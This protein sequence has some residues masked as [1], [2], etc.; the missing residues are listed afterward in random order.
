[1]WITVEKISRSITTK[2]TCAVRV[3]RFT[4]QRSTYW[5]NRRL[6][7]WSSTWCI[8][9]IFVIFV[10]YFDFKIVCV[11]SPG[12]HFRRNVLQSSRQNFK[13]DV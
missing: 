12:S 11:N 3:A 10:L 13:V 6:F 4:V 9:S 7:K 2:V 8:Y 5:A 1:V